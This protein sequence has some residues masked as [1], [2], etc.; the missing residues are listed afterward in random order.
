[1]EPADLFAALEVT[2]P[3]A[4]R[5]ALLSCLPVRVPPALLRLIRLRLV[6]GGT[7]GDEA[8]LWL[9]DLVETRSVG[10]FGFRAPVR[11]Y[12]RER[13]RADVLLLDE[14]WSRVHIEHGRWIGARTRLEEELTWRLLRQRDD[15]AIELLWARVVE[16][17]A[18]GPNAEGV[19]RWVVRAVADLPAGTRDHPSGQRAY[20][21]A[22]LLLGDAS[23]LGHEPQQFLGAGEF[24]FATRKLPRRRIFVGL[25]DGAILVS[26]LREIENGH[27]ID[28]PATQPLWLQLEPELESRTGPTV[29]TLDDNEPIRVKTR[30]PVTVRSIDG[31]AYALRPLRDGA[32]EPI[33]RTR[34]PR[35]QIE[36]DVEL[37]G[38]EKKIQLPFV[39]G[40][41][42]DLSGHPHQ[43]PAPVEDRKFLEIDIDNFDARMKAVKPRVAFQVP[44][45]LTGKGDVSV[46]LTF[47][48]IDDFSPVGVARQ[49]EPLDLLLEDRLRLADLMTYL[50]GSARA[51][52]VVS[53]LLRD[54]TVLR[55][56]ADQRPTRQ[57]LGTLE[58]EDATFASTE[59]YSQLR[60]EFQPRT[61]EAVEPLLR[62]L[63][64]QVLAN[65]TLLT[66]DVIRSIEAIVGQLDT[67]LTDQMNAILHHEDFQK[68]ESA[69]RGLAY[70]VQNTETDEMLKIRILNISKSELGET[71]ARYK[72]VQWD[73]S[74]VFKKVYEAEYGQFGGEPYSCLVGDYYFDHSPADTELLGEI[75]RTAAAAFSPFLA[76]A[77]PAVLQM[78][79]WQELGAPRDLTNLLDAPEYADWL[80]LR[81]SEDARYLGLALPRFLARA[82]YGRNTNP[83]DEFD[84]E[85]D[86]SGADSS[87]Y[88]WANAAYAMAVNITRSFRTYGWCARIVGLE[89]GGLVEGLPTDTFPTDRGDV[90]MNCPTEIA[91]SDRRAVEFG[92]NGF[93]PLVHRRNSDYAV[94]VSANSLQKPVQYV[95]TDATDNA[96][97]VAQFPYLF[98]CLRFTHYLKCIVRDKIGNF[99]ERQDMQAWLQHW[100]ANYVESD[101]E[102]SSDRTKALKPLRSADVRVDEVEDNPGYYSAALF[103]QPHYQLEDLTVS[104]RLITPLP[105]TKAG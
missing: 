7:T 38:A 80:A 14:L 46:D 91:I 30:T 103:L 98:G 61:Y 50:D 96:R 12:L 95:D 66:A 79:S 5:L 68:L 71:L 70:L 94:F 1:M 27:E 102:H 39:V 82:P 16:E 57:R 4:A 13:L 84:F 52:D 81:G 87:R 65:P 56:L 99:S 53:R 100:I 58:P 42:A 63:A 3:L 9:S 24:S 74:P 35:V 33:R 72:G 2:R 67:S 15:D 90:A 8:D 31:A 88:T 25:A 97:R 76:A 69:W 23:V 18:T 59:L 78:A 20:Y 32:Q 54:D 75:A 104:L 47:N 93:M 11:G 73:Q 22:H 43:P 77:S 10:G 34:A 62:T 89:T 21:G 29:V 92:R 26:P 36:Y 28:V 37:Y 41:L 48:S 49:V 64:A 101:P 60:T 17:L 51:A 85:E 86:T 44:N 105:S 40:V 19:A 6:P 83:V 55:T 45:T